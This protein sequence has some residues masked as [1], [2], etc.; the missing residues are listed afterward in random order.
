[1]AKRTDQEE[2]NTAGADTHAEVPLYILDVCMAWE[3]EGDSE[4]SRRL[5]DF[6]C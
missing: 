6:V 3:R 5:I 1:M 4:K 2:E